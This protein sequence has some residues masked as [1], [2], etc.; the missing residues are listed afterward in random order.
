MEIWTEQKFKDF[1]AWQFSDREKKLPEAKQFT[2]TIKAEFKH[3]TERFY[4]RDEQRWLI[5]KAKFDLFM[6]IYWS[7][8]KSI[9]FKQSEMEFDG[10]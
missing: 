2:E 8:I 10:S 5:H 9:V 6:D 4:F 7:F 3:K 1:F